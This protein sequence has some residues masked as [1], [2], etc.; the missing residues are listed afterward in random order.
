ML[1]LRQH[2]VWLQIFIVQTFRIK[3]FILKNLIFGI[4][5]LRI[6][7]I[8]VK[9]QIDMSYNVSNITHL[10][11]FCFLHAC[12]SNYGTSSPAS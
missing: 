3:P 5:F 11:E 8:F 9:I 6:S 4:K 7:I 12:A 10:N 1:H 2:T